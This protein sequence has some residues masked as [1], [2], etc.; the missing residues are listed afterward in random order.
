MPFTDSLCSRG[1]GETVVVDSELE[2]LAALV[3]P[4]DS[5]FGATFFCGREPLFNQCSNPSWKPK[6]PKQIGHRVTPTPRCEHGGK[7][8]GLDSLSKTDPAVIEGIR[9][10]AQKS[11]AEGRP[12]AMV[13]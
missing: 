12:A 2:P 10:M 1:E 6:H 3:N 9:L 5:L 8:V 7:A 13:L 4:E 11:S